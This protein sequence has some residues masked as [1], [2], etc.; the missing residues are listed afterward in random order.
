MFLVTS[1][2][3]TICARQIKP[4]TLTSQ[5]YANRSSQTSHLFLGFCSNTTEESSFEQFISIYFFKT[6][7][8]DV[9]I[10]HIFIL[11]AQRHSSYNSCKLKCKPAKKHSMNLIFR[12]IWYKFSY[13][14][15]VKLLAQMTSKQEHFHR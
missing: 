14:L 11:K 12:K 10:L 6:L 1:R 3:L 7:G 8:T 13:I 4:Q 2:L 5:E 15:A 9:K